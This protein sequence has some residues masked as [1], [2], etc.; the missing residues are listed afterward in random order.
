MSE[1]LTV[2]VPLAEATGQPGA[3]P[4]SVWIGDG[5]M[6]HVGEKIRP[7]HRGSKVAV[8]TDS[9]VAPIYGDVVMNSLRD[10][11]LEPTLVVVEAGEASKRMEIVSQVIDAM[12]AGL[13]PSGRSTV[14]KAVDFVLGPFGW[15]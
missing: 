1:I 6:A 4:Y 3:G 5:L 11:G 12:I 7:L 10:V 2:N 15:D 14:E 9:N 8:V 13:S